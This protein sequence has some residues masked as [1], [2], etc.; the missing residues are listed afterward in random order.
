MSLRGRH[1]S[2]AHPTPMPPTAVSFVARR[3]PTRT[4]VSCMAITLI[5]TPVEYKFDLT[6]VN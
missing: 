3:V 6:Q 2:A 1:I 4:V 5:V